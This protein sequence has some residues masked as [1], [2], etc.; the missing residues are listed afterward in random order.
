MVEVIGI[1][2]CNTVK[3]TLNWLDENGIEWQLRDVKKDPLTPNELAGLVGKVGLETLVNRKGRK[4]KMLGL[5]D[6]ELSDNDIFDV[7]LENQTVIKRPVLVYGESIMVGFDES[8]LS[9]F[10]QSDQQ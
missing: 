5:S 1:K 2:N 3:K 9:E 10:L 4:W 6:K 8:S 7:L